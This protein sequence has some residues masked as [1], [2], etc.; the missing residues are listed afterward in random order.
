MK[1]GD[2]VKCWKSGYK[3]SDYR[4]TE[5]I[6][7]IAPAFQ[8]KS[9]EMAYTLESGERYYVSPSPVS[10]LCHNVGNGAFWITP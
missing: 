7:D 6:I 8:G 10:G 2:R 3:Y 4:K 5:Q 1:I 9:S